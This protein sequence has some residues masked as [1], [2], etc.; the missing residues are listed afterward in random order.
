MRNNDNEEDPKKKTILHTCETP[1]QWSSLIFPPSLPPLQPDFPKLLCFLPLLLWYLSLSRSLPH[2]HV[3]SP[4]PHSISSSPPAKTPKPPLS[5]FL[6]F[7]CFFPHF[8]LQQPK[9]KKKRSFF[10]SDSF[11]SKLSLAATSSSP[12]PILWPPKAARF[13]EWS[14][15]KTIKRTISSLSRRGVY[16][17]LFKINDC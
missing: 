1:L 9:I 17:Y 8:S 10:L 5:S 15:D 14:E 2:P 11:S 3:L 12:H 6:F 7:C 4:A 13:S 16:K